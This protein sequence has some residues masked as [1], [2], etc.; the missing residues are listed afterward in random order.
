MAVGGKDPGHAG[1]AGRGADGAHDEQALAAEAVN[2]RHADQGEE[3]VGGA[4]G[5]GL[6]IAGK[7]AEA[8]GRK[9][10]VH[11]AEDGVDAGELVEGA[12]GDG[13]E[14]RIAVLP[15]ED[16]L[17]HGGVLRIHGGLNL[18]ELGLGI[19]TAHLRSTP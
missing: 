12:D 1:E 18:G 9:D 11:V 10:G 5:D 19:G 3:E 7:L 4:D 15:A 6:L 16:R 14:E 8:G 13:Q 17:V 2:E